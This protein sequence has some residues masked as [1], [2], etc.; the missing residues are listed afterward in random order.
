M[1]R[2]AR[3]VLEDASWPVPC[4][5]NAPFRIFAVLMLALSCWSLLRR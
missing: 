4:G 2:R 1:T 3:A 5:P